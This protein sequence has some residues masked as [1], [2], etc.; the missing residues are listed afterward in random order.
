M[1]R[2]K[3]AVNRKGTN[4]SR[5]TKEAQLKSMQAM[6]TDGTPQESTGGL[7]NWIK[8]TNIF[9]RANTQTLLPTTYTAKGHSPR[10]GL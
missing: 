3:G 10:K 5:M 2:N 7:I 6:S 9:S 4:A 1:G 8:G